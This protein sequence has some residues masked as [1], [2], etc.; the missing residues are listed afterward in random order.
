[1]PAEPK[2]SSDEPERA[3]PRLSFAELYKSHFAFVW[4]NL[5]RLGVPEARLRDAAQDAFLVVHR[6]L[7]EFEGR[8]TVQ[9]W[10]YSIVRRVAAD[11]R[12][13][14]LRKSP[15][16]G[17]LAEALRDETHPDPEDQ[18]ARGE[19]MRLLL[20]FLAELDANRRELLILVDLEGLSVSEAAAVLNCNLNTAF[21]RLKSARHHMQTGLERYRANEWR[22]P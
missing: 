20:Q 3:V 6:R 11:H 22:A 15:S 19:E 17:E 10:L 1:L 16:G 4:R 13:N 21:T 14:I 9:A 18:A 5:R 12:R 2:L 8:G 7:N